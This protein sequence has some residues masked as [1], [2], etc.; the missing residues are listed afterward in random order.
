MSPARSTRET[1][2]QS[3]DFEIEKGMKGLRNLQFNLGRRFEV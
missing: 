2:W 3:R 1:I